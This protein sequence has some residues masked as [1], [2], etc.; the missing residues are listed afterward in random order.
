MEK[1]GSGGTDKI[2]GFFKV[3]ILTQKMQQY[4]TKKKQT[5]DKTLREEN[6]D[7]V[8]LEKYLH[9]KGKWN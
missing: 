7:E 3:I 9:S 4:L 1:I 5:Q 8:V 6:L 2:L